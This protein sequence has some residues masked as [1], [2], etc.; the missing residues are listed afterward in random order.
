MPT[1]N[2]TFS[3]TTT[4][5]GTTVSLATKDGSYREVI[6]ENLSVDPF[7]NRTHQFEGGYQFR[8]PNI[9]LEEWE[10]TLQSLSMLDG[11]FAISAEVDTETKNVTA[12]IRIA[13]KEDA[14]MFA[15]TNVSVWQKWGDAQEQ[16]LKEDRKASRTPKIFVDKD[17]NLKAKV[18]VNSLGS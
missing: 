4:M 17:G 15:W 13:E 6:A 3:R 7:K 1:K 2:P 16:E 18:R 8:S 14:A 5:F 9:P 10:G 12:K 11:K